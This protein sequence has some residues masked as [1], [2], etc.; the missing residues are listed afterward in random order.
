M[1]GDSWEASL[2][3][4]REGVT[5]RPENQAH[6]VCGYCFDESCG[7]TCPEAL[8]G[9]EEKLAWLPTPT[10]A[11]SIDTIERT[12]DAF[13][14][15]AAAKFI[16][17][18]ETNRGIRGI[19]HASAGGPVPVVM[20][21]SFSE[22]TGYNVGD[23]AVV[24]TLDRLIP[25][26]IRGEVDLFPTM[27]P[28]DFGFVVADL[29]STLRHLNILSPLAS[30]VPNEV[31]MNEAPGAGGAV[32]DALLNLPPGSVIRDTES[33]L[34]SVRLDPLVTAGWR[35][36][37]LL[38]VAIILFTAASGCATYML[39]FSGRGRTEAGFMRSLG[40]SRRQLSGLLSLEHVVVVVMGLSLGTWSGIEMSRRMVASVAV[41]DQGDA[42]LPPFSLITDWALMGPIYVVLLVVFGVAL[43]AL[44][45]S[46][47]G[48]D[49]QTIARLEG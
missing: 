32:R 3:T 27:H 4:Y 46:M 14:D 11:V 25:V 30:I 48:V 37:G 10:S 1:I 20:S 28:E 6:F 5:Q 15:E 45:R 38:A 40:M 8:D 47:R 23:L 39:A 44:D 16:F 42:V 34:E 43:Y 9:F 12:D 22:R 18:K 36:M 19:Y 24:S 26:A 49:I 35:A 17:G 33:A 29:D 7:Q 13:S 41:T 21:S 31:L 2:H